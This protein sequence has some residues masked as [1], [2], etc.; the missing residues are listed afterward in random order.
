MAIPRTVSRHL[1]TVALAA[2]VLATA[3]AGC[4]VVPYPDYPGYQG[5]PAYG[6]SAYPAPVVV[7]PPV[8]GFYG[9]G[10]Y[11]HSHRHWR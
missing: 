11:H 2:V 8:F 3:L 1:A 10:G 6:Y 9:G 7:A 4:A 5:Y